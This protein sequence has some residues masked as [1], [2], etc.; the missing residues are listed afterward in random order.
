MIVNL[1]VCVA[2]VKHKTQKVLFV[3]DRNFFSQTDRN[4]IQ[5][6]FGHIF[7]LQFIKSCNCI[8]SIQHFWKANFFLFFFFHSWFLIWVLFLQ[9]EMKNNLQFFLSFQ[10]TK[11]T[12]SIQLTSLQLLVIFDDHLWSHTHFN[13]VNFSQYFV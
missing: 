12:K 13:S 9:F 4:T 3:S 2:S 1:C 10:F 6:I 7:F 11:R 5:I 8:C